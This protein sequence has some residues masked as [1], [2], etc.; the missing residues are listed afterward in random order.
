ML[1]FGLGNDKMHVTLYF[2]G[3]IEYIVNKFDKTF[4][5]QQNSQL[6]LL[7]LTDVKSSQEGSLKELFSECYS[8]AHTENPSSFIGHPRLDVSGMYVY[9]LLHR[10]RC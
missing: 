6:E 3:A 1:F 7:E 10:G 2:V 5:H 8:E 4:P 9:G